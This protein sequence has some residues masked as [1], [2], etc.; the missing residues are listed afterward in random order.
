MV[1]QYREEEAMS[2]NAA[3][4]LARSR[5]SATERWGGATQ[6][7]LPRTFLLTPH[8]PYRHIRPYQHYHTDS[9][10]ICGAQ[11]VDCIWR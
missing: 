10:E 7:D 8:V 4:V 5:T 2:G 11:R 1:V 6:I 3:E 9:G